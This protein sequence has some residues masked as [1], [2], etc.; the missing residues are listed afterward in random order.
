MYRCLVSHGV[1]CDIRHMTKEGKY[2][3]NTSRRRKALRRDVSTHLA[4]KLCRPLV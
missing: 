4:L 2:R 1:W 3:R